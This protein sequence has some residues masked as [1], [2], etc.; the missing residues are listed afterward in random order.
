MQ[1]VNPTTIAIPTPFSSG[2]IVEWLDRYV[3]CADANGWNEDQRLQ[4]LSP[5]LTGQANLLY[6]RLQPNQRDTWAHLRANLIAQFYPAET[7]TTRKIEFHTNRHNAGETIDAYA[8]RLERK[9]EQ[10]M[11]ELVDSNAA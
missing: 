7:S 2:D 3:V 9:L 11:P 8:Y 5:Y 4:R 6:R 1:H 10:A